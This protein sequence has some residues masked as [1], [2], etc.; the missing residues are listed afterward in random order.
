MDDGSALCPEP[1]AAAPGAGPPPPPMVASAP[2][3]RMQIPDPARIDR[4][5]DDEEGFEYLGRGVG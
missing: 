1:R 5:M 3:F 4:V 2:P